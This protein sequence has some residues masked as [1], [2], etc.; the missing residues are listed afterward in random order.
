MKKV[1]LYAVSFLEMI[2]TAG[3][4]ANAVYKLVVP[5]LILCMALPAGAQVVSKSLIARQLVMAE[6]ADGRP[7]N[8]ELNTMKVSSE[9]FSQKSG[10]SHVY[11]QQYVNDIPVYN[12]IMNVHVTRENKL[13]TFS[14]RFVPGAAAK[15]GKVFPSLTAEQAVNATGRV[16]WYKN[17]TEL[18]S[19][20]ISGSAR[21]ME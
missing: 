2:S 8:E 21:S 14:S 15:A 10:V 17:Q 19:A 9:T 16:W 6:Q 5:L 18:D 1:H 3:K 4:T 13:L 11:F 20:P 12:A 7:V